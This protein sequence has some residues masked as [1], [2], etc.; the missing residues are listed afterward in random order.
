METFLPEAFIAPLRLTTSRRLVVEMFDE[1][2]LFA[3][4]YACV[5]DLVTWPVRVEAVQT[6]VRERYEQHD[7]MLDLMK[8]LHGQ[9]P[10]SIASTL[11]INIAEGLEVVHVIGVDDY[12]DLCTAALTNAIDLRD[13][14]EECGEDTPRGRIGRLAGLLGLSEMETELLTFAFLHAVLPQF[15]LLS[16]LVAERPMT[17]QLYWS[18]LLGQPDQSDRELMAALSAQGRLAGSGLVRIEDEVPTVSPFWARA[19]LRS[20]SS[21]G[22]LLL[23]PLEHKESPGGMSRLPGEDGEII[24]QL[25]RTGGPGR[26]VLIHGKSGV[27]KLNLAQRLI[28]AAGGVAYTLQEDIPEPDRPAA[29]L[30][31]QRLLAERSDRHPVLVVPRA[32][33]IL[34]RSRSES[35]SFFGLGDEDEDTVKSLDEQLLTEAPVPGLWIMSDPGRLNSETLARFLFHAEALRGTRADRTKMI[36]LLIDELPVTDQDKTELAK[37][38]GLSAQQ[39][40]S[41]RAL[42]GLTAG[43]CAAKYARNLLVAAARSQRALS[44]RNKDEVRTSVTHYSVD[45]INSAGRFGPGQILRALMQRPQGSLCLYGIPGTG[46]TQFAEHIAAELGKPIL[47]KRASDIFGKY[48]GESEK[49]IAAMFDQAEEEDAVLLLDE[50]DSFLRERARSTQHWEVS[51][52]NELLQRMERFLC[53]RR[54]FISSWIWRRY[55]GSRSSWNCFHWGWISAGKCFGVRRDWLTGWCRSSLRWSWRNGC[56]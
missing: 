46:K 39:L 41:A 48:L 33:A 23:T 42:A 32:Q 29:M 22:Q 53:A 10:I 19:L 9:I 56:S 26:N 40:V 16:Y 7:Q 20:E 51:T 4:H 44:R 8:K 49:E 52:V 11:A 18:S 5:A 13:L 17:R 54:I 35:F 21:L 55:E 31:G 43:P 15:K 27:D 47:V 24:Q 36:N 50:A 28:D 37:L 14:A 3:A 30:L 2:I 38:E 45:Y 12:R 6:A 1:P 34:S 25:L